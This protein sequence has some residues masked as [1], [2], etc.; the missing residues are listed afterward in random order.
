MSQVR[1][2]APD[3]ISDPRFANEGPG[4]L[5]LST[6]ELVG[7]M[8]SEVAGGEFPGAEKALLNK[9]FGKEYDHIGLGET[10]EDE[11]YHLLDEAL[12]QLTPLQRDVLMQRIVEGKSF[13]EIGMMQDDQLDQRRVEKMYDKV[14]EETRKYI[15]NKI[16]ASQGGVLQETRDSAA[17]VGSVQDKI[18]TEERRKRRAFEYRIKKGI[19][20]KLFE[21]PA[22][23]ERYYRYSMVMNKVDSHIENMRVGVLD[24]INGQE[25]K[26]LLKSFAA[27][28]S[29]DEESVVEKRVNQYIEEAAQHLFSLL[30]HWY[31]KETR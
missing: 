10:N 24:K 27:R 8:T 12:E 9:L 22:A 30:N 21:F 3:M 31:E 5:E 19:R 17:D 20:D 29:A 14:F 16:S 28:L 23:R 13:A 15:L 1:G 25:K 11:L 7:K 2:K 4:G 26:L 18:H 6:K